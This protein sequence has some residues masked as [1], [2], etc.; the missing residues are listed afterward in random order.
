M[1]WGSTATK[2]DQIKLWWPN[3]RQKSTRRPSPG[4]A[5][6]DWLVWKPILGLVYF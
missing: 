1:T 3:E 6:T 5:L 4:T 2:L